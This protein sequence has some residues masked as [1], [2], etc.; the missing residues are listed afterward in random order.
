MPGSDTRRQTGGSAAKDVDIYREI[1]IN[2]IYERVAINSNHDKYVYLAPEIVIFNYY[3]GKILKQLSATA[4]AVL[5][6]F[7]CVAQNVN[8]ESGLQQIMQNHDVVGL[9][10]AVVKDGRIIYTKALGSKDLASNTALKENDLFRI[11]SISKSFSATAMMQLI[12]ARKVSLDDDFSKL[13]GFKIRNPR[14]PDKVITLRMVLSHTSSINDSQGYFEFDV[15]NPDKNSNWAKSYNAYAPGDGY[16]YC[17]LNFNMVGAVIERLSGERFDTYINNHI[18]RPLGLYGGY[19][20]DSLDNSLFATLYAYDP[21]SGFEPSPGAYAPRTE[22]IAQYV[23]SYSTP[24]FSPTGGMKI[25]VPDLAKYMMMHMNR[26][27]SENVR[28][29]SRKSS[30]RMQK[31]VATKEG[32]GLA[33]TTVENLI[34]DKTMV[35][36]TGNAYGLYSA[37]FFHPEEKFGF[38]VITNGCKPSYT[39]DMNSVVREAMISLY[40]DL[41][42]TPTDDR[43]KLKNAL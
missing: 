24:V 32:Y 5:V 28:I 14:Y 38:V 20:V 29:I 26:G 6:S 12:E 13:V 37:M 34:P 16:Q 36:H 40:E 21:A 15:I 10:V 7:S 23:M 3:M 25:S 1:L 33:L 39:D 35:G 9:S 43:K 11:A 18:L 30:K 17:N 22:D 4:L 41:I 8:A 19:C 2:R 31:P 42:K 27:T